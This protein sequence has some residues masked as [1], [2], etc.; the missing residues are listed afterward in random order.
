M[1]RRSL[2]KF[3]G[4]FLSVPVL[5]ATPSLQPECLQPK[6]PLP[7]GDTR[8]PVALAFL[9]ALERGGYVTVYY[10]GGS[11]PG[12]MRK[13]TPQAVFRLVTG[14]HLYATGTCHLRKETRTLRLDRA[15]L[16]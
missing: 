16:G 8:D 6:D 10:H 11:T 7:P 14:G 13:F 1:T 15:R 2:A 9:A 5:Q 3:F 4:A 12:A